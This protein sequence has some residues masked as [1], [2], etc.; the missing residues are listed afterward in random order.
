MMHRLRGSWQVVRDSLWFIPTLM[1]LGAIVLAIGMV[2]TSGVV[3]EKVL[4][5]YPRL[6]GADANSSRAMLS[7]IAGAMMTVAGVTFSITMVAVT[8]AATQFT[9][10]IL[11]NFMRDRPNQ[12]T[13]GTLTGVFV[14]CLIVIRTIRGNEH[15]TFVPELAVLVAFALAIVAIGMLVYFIHH[16][17]SSLQASSILARVAADTGAAVDRLFPEE[18]GEEAPAAVAEAAAE[19][20]DRPW[21]PVPAAANGYVSSVDSDGLLSF[22]DKH[23]I[24]V[25]MERGVGEYVVRDTPLVSVLAPHFTP[26]DE[27]AINNLFTIGNVRTVDQ[28]AAFGIRQ[29]VDLGL[30]ALSPAV[31]NPSTGINSIHA[32]GAVLAAVANR[33]IENPYRMCEGRLR[34]IARGPTF[35]SLVATGVDEIRQNAGAHVR[36][37]V[38]LLEMLAVVAAHTTSPRRHAVL[39]SHAGRVHAAG[40]RAVQDP[41]DHDAVAAAYVRV[42]EA[43]RT[44]L[45]EALRSQMQGQA[46]G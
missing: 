24:V 17:A 22:A 21:R 8:Q 42:Q 1:I 19:L 4:A 35:E 31:N 9:S 16:V 33:R 37:F 25:R 27:R 29:M 13:L 7:T 23:D 34:V 36:V 2:M 10:R 26:A 3:D 38:E 28:D 18:L 15:T 6:F 5:R 14:Y 41:A 40:D 43:S 20:A 46:P 39:L 30:R 45:Q 12:V 11:R 32:V 44:R